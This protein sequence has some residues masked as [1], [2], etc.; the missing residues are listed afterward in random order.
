VLDS[1]KEKDMDS[2]RVDERN[3]D[4]SGVGDLE[5]PSEQEVD[6][7]LAES[8]PASD[9]PPWTPAAAAVEVVIPRERR[10][11]SKVGEAGGADV[12]RLLT[13]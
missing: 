8:F 1:L 7:V 6:D 9:P 5:G 12:I 3:P 10:G 4:L 2:M 11:L 13:R